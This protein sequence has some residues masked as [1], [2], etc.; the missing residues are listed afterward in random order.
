MNDKKKTYELMDLNVMEVSAVDS[1]A[2]EHAKMVLLKNLTEN[3]EEIAKA[4]FNAL[5]QSMEVDEAISK[6]MDK[7]WVLNRALR[8]SFYSVIRDKEIKNKKEEMKKTLKQYMDVAMKIVGTLPQDT[9]VSKIAYA[10]G[11]EIVIPEELIK[12]KDK[13]TAL[14][15]ELFKEATMAEETKDTATIQEAV[16]KAV[17]EALNSPDIEELKTLAKLSDLEKEHLEKLEGDARTGFL[18]ASKEERAV[19]IKKTQKQSL[20]DSD[21]DILVIKGRKVTRESVGD[22]AFE[23]MKLQQ[24]DLQEQ[25]K[26][27]EETRKRNEEVQEL[28]AFEKCLHQGE[29]VYKHIPVE[30]S[31]KG[32]L[33][34][35]MEKNAPSDVRESFFSV[36]KSAEEAMESKM[37]YMGGEIGTGLDSTGDDSAQ[38]QLD[39]LADVYASKNNCTIEKAMD[40]VLKTK[41][42]AELYDSTIFE[43]WSII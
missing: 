42:G 16:N 21:D 18:K 20:L 12:M 43:G 6:M 19:L 39:K 30:K 8:E 5:L 27:M 17:K 33:L 26:M 35:F 23:V 9:P 7:F 32:K 36:L 25:R 14:G 29:T 1:P 31:A 3:E 22:A 37:K 34:R 13:I 10:D 4:D 40:A 38:A 24:E 41:E 2:N 28:S 11:T 15:G